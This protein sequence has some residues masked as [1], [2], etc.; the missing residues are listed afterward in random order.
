MALLVG[1]LAA[2]QQSLLVLPTISQCICI[3]YKQANQSL[4]IGA[5]AHTGRVNLYLHVTAPPCSNCHLI[6]SR[7]AVCQTNTCQTTTHNAHHILWQTLLLNTQMRCSSPATQGMPWVELQA[8]CAGFSCKQA[9]TELTVTH[10]C[11]LPTSWTRCNAASRGLPL[12]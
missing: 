12:A 2:V 11:R 8:G 1:N 6:M 5:V 7:T 4:V 9:D 3:H 10:N